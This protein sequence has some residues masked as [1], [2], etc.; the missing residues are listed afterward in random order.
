LHLLSRQ[1]LQAGVRYLSLYLDYLKEDY[2]K[3]GS[4]IYVFLGVSKMQNEVRPERS[5]WRDEVISKW[6]KT[7]DIF[8]PT[9]DVD[10]ILTGFGVSES[11]WLEFD[12]DTPW[13]I[14]EYKLRDNLDPSTVEVNHSMRACL[15][16]ANQA[17]LPYII[18]IHDRACH[19][20]LVKL[21][22]DYAV[23][24]VKS[25]SFAPDKISSEWF[26]LCERNMVRFF[27]LLHNK[28]AEDHIDL[29]KFYSD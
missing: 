16:L 11:G 25:F 10:A 15:A 23:D 1:V 13:A 2:S 20:F 29:N 7:L 24:K 9:T 3:D 12:Y 8:V 22:N 4:V 17:S 18:V 5:G 27:Y 14:I 6:H 21:V 26:K 19:N 28:K